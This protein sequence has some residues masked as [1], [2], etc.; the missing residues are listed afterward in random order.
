MSEV[1]LLEIELLSSTADVSLDNYFIFSYRITS[2][3]LA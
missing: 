2:F 1:H 3:G